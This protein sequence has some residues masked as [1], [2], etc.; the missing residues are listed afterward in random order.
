MSVLYKKVLH[1][2]MQLKNSIKY[3]VCVCCIVSELIIVKIVTLW[4]YAVTTIM[5]LQFITL[6]KKFH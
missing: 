6:D 5:I 4:L 2:M 3:E 1:I